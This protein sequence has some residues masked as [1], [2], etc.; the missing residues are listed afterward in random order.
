MHLAVG[1]V[2][3]IHKKGNTNDVNNYRGIE[4]I[5]CFA[6]LFTSILNTRLKIGLQM[7]TIAQMHNLGLRQNIVLSM[8][9][10]F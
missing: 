8:P 7:L 5:S 1:M 2:V 10:L 9:L 4:L 3:P 6:K